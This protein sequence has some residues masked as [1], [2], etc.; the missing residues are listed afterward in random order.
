MSEVDISVHNVGRFDKSES[1]HIN[2]SDSLM[3]DEGVVEEVRTTTSRHIV[4]SGR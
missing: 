1:L 4:K 3:G 2:D